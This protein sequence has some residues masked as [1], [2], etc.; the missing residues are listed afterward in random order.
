[1]LQVVVAGNSVVFSNK[2]G[3][4]N[5]RSSAETLPHSTLWENLPAKNTYYPLSLTQ[6]KRYNSALGEETCQD[7]DRAV[8]G[9]VCL[10]TGFSVHL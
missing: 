8:G 7:P 4:S 5:H 2:F 9:K 1:M 10:H 3:N 6:L